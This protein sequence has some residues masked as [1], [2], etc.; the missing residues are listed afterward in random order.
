MTARHAVA[1]YWRL[2]LAGEVSNA[3]VIVQTHDGEW[4]M[5]TQTYEP[6]PEPRRRK[7]VGEGRYR[8]PEARA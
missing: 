3:M 1:E 2:W 4:R 8:G 6:Y 5:L 7:P